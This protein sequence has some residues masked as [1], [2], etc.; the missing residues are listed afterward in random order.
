MVGSFVGNLWGEHSDAKSAIYMDARADEDQRQALQMIFGGQVGGWPARLGEIMGP[1][2]ILGLEFVPIEVEIA[3]D[4][5][6]WRAEV[7]G[8]AVASAE[9]LTGPTARPEQRVQT[10]NPPG[11]EVGPGA[12]ATWGRA[13]ADRVDAFGFS[14][15][16]AGRSSKHMAF[17]WSGPD[18][19]G[20]G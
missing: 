3:H 16:R 5:T 20:S 15:D 4:L 13:T 7:P 18:E 9:A 2:E 6:R 12:V 17:D 11:S 10:L 19:P 1:E 8:R 14:W